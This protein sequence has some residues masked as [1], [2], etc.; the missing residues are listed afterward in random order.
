MNA[1]HPYKEDVEMKASRPFPDNNH[2]RTSFLC[3]QLFDCLAEDAWYC[4]YA[5]A[6]GSGFFCKHP[7]REHFCCDPDDR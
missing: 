1:T 3:Q 5:M 2:C 6:F 4:P 7:D